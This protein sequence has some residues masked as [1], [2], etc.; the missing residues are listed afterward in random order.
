[1]TAVNNPH[2]ERQVAAIDFVSCKSRTIPF[3]L[4][5]TTGPAGLMKDSTLSGK[6]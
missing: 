1:M 4:A 2:P 5:L 6:H 3:V